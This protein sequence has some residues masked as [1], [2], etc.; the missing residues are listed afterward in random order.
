MGSTGGIVVI[1]MII[2]C[3][4]IFLFAL[5]LG[6]YASAIGRISVS[7]NPLDLEEAMVQQMKF[8]RLSGIS[9]LVMIV[10]IIVASVLSS[11]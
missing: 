11:L 9:T 5:R 8:W 6:S 10:L 2:Y 1:V 4:I 7:R 3:V